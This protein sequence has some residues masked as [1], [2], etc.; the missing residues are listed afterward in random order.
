MS[1]LLLGSRIIFFKELQFC[2]HGQRGAGPRKELFLCR[3][4]H[5]QQRKIR[6]H[7]LAT[8]GETAKAL[9]VTYGN[10]I[11]NL[12]LGGVEVFEYSN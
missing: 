1:L 4:C 6:G 9:Y 11:L 3:D 8:S 10:Q 7:R 5:G 2:A 12:R